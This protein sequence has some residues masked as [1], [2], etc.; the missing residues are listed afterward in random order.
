MHKLNQT[1]ASR[2]GVLNSTP[3]KNGL[4]QAEKKVSGSK[5]GD[6]LDD[7][8]IKLSKSSQFSPFNAE[9]ETN[10]KKKLKLQN[11]SK[12]I[13]LTDSRKVKHQFPLYRDTDLG[14]ERGKQILVHASTND[15]DFFTDDEQLQST[16][17]YCIHQVK[18]GINKEQE[19][20]SQFGDISESE[21]SF[22]DNSKREKVSLSSGSRLELFSK[23]Y[24]T[25]NN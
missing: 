19:Q 7:T 21:Y 5:K 10:K 9:N 11:E 13:E 8:I 24:S 23:G 15:D 20:N 14:I 18:E 3:F 17:R 22:S 4:G 6:N 2:R 25:P 1:S 12:K 16:V